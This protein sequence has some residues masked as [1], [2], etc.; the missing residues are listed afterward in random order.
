MA[1]FLQLAEGLSDQSQTAQLKHEHERDETG[2]T[3]AP[4][5]QNAG[6]ETE[7]QAERSCSISAA[8]SVVPYINNY[9]AHLIGTGHSSNISII[10]YAK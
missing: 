3:R 8:C 9:E 10:G 4:E 1:A 2:R 5:T 7:Q 6:E